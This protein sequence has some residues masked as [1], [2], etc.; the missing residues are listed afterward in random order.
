MGMFSK[1]ESQVYVVFHTANPHADKRYFKTAAGAKRATTCANRNAGKLV[2]NWVEESWF[3]LKY[4][5]GMKTVK[6]LMSGQ[7][8]QIP[9][10][11]PYC[12]DPSTERYWS[13]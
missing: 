10:D 4:P 8:V 13:M 2:Y 3:L 12:C 7:E 6:N 9:A 1:K 5:V 11:T